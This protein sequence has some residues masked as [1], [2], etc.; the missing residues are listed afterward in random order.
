MFGQPRPLICYTRDTASVKWFFPNRT[1]VRSV[2][3]DTIPSPARN[4][5]IYSWD[6]SGHGV[7]LHRALDFYYTGEYCC[8]RSGTTQ[9][10]CVNLSK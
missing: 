3:T 2:P 8:K 7:S 4:S 1:Q 10:L 9:R 5:E 6:G